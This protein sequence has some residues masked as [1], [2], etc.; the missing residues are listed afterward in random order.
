MKKF[1][2][3]KEALN[4][5]ARSGRSGDLHYIVLYKDGSGRITNSYNP[6]KNDCLIRFDNEED[7]VDK[8][9]LYI[10]SFSRLL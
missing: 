5:A 8:L 7:M 9:N 10:D 6:H 3:I 1:K 2:L 4:F